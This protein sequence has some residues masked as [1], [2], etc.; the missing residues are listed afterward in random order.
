MEQ[1]WTQEKTAQLSALVE[2][3]TALNKPVNWG[4]V[5]AQ[6]PGTSRMQC[7]AKYV[8]PHLSGVAELER[9][10]EWSPLE[11]ELLIECVDV[12]GKDWN[13]IQRKCFTWMTP[14]KLKNKHYALSKTQSERD[15]REVM[16]HKAEMKKRRMAHLDEENV[17][18]TIRQILNIK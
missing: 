5:S 16:L 15:E 18:R 4:E 10:H 6:C 8:K 12:Y 14:L 2:Q 1:L 17:Y 11:K 3:Y 7:K 13:K 9:Y